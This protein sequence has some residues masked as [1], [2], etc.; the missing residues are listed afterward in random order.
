M[1]MASEVCILV[2]TCD[3]YRAVAE[4]TKHRIGADWVGHPPLFIH[5]LGDERD[6]MTVA[7][8]G[9]E[10]CLA[11]GFRWIYL[12]LDDHPPVGK[13]NADVLNKTLPQLARRLEAVNICL[14]GWGQRREKEGLVLSSRDGALRRNDVSFRWKFSLHPALW[15][16]EKLHELL[17]IR[18]GQFYGK[19]RTA[20]NFERHRDQ[21]DGPVGIDLLSNTYRVHGTSMAVPGSAAF[22]LLRQPALIGFDMFRFVLRIVSGQ[23]RRDRFDR[24]NLWLYHYYRGPY[25]ILWSGSMR[26]GAPSRDFEN[27]LRFTGRSSLSQEWAETKKHLELPC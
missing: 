9:V 19:D 13:C 6:W 22:E 5:G 20:W 16:A 17:V 18:L 24:D 11:Q 10:D 12:I 25:P 14:L 2:L 21:A 23:E 4:W 26:Q 15:Y 3:R 1:S 7:R 8:D 27:F